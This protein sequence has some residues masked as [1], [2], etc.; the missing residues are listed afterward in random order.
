ML[1][2]F[3]VYRIYEGQERGRRKEEMFTVMSTGSIVPQNA[4]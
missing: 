1:S 4:R 2:S 3:I